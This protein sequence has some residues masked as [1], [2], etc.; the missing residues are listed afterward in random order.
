MDIIGCSKLPSDEQQ[1]V[2]GRLQEL[3]RESAAFRRSHDSDQLISL[4]TGD[5]MALVFF[6]KLDA[7]VQCAMEITQSIQSESLCK[8]R[9]GVHTGLVFVMEDINHKR[10]IFC[11]PSR[12]F[13]GR[14][15]RYSVGCTMNTGWRRW[16]A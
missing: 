3:V 14:L 9:M 6:N 5:G 7:A 1:R 4:P 11:P 12:R 8:I 15:Q 2:V 10:N 13:K 16:A